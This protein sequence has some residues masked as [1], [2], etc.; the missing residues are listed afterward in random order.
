[1]SLVRCPASVVEE[2][3][4]SNPSL[5]VINAVT[6]KCE[7]LNLDSF[8]ALRC[9]KELRLKSTCG[10]SI[11][12]IDSLRELKTLKILSLTSVTD[13]H[14]LDLTVMAELVNLEWLDLGECT[15]FPKNFGSD[16]L[17]KLQRLEKLRLEKVN[18][19]TF[20]LVRLA[21]F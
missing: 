3:T 16:I 15:D 20:A 4:K 10:L 6:I 18:F 1:M 17:L 11:K 2:L 8:N 7:S 19:G 9:V 13:L 12:S 5:E 14:K 21:N